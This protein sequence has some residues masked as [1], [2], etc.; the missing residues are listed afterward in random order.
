MDSGYPPLL[1]CDR[2]TTGTSEM[3]HHCPAIGQARPGSFHS[4][5]EPRQ[6]AREASIIERA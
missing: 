1:P 5:T 3:Q 4:L 6:I 2:E